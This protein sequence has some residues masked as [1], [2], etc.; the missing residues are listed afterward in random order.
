[1]MNDIFQKYGK[2]PRLFRDAIITEKLDGT[3]AQVL[4]ERIDGYESPY[5]GDQLA[6]NPPLD[7]LRVSPE[8]KLGIWAGSR[9]RLIE[10]GKS[11]DNYG[12]AGWVQENAPALFRLGRGRYYGEWYGRGIARHYDLD[13]K[14]WALFN[15]SFEDRVRGVGLPNVETVPVIEQSTLSTFGVTHAV[16]SLRDHGSLA[17]PGFMQPEGV[18]VY[19]TQSKQVYKVLLENDEIPK[20]LV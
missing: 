7:V 14:R 12:F 9:N 6:D 18:I 1:M 3:N 16:N 11:T 4:I 5:T 13:H 10:P 15:P 19:H 8:E 20:G 2:T 17:A